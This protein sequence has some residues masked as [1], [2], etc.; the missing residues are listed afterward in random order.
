VPAQ[1]VKERQGIVPDA[2]PPAG[3]EAQYDELT[4]PT[5]TRRPLLGMLLTEYERPVAE[6]GT[7]TLTD[8]RGFCPTFRPIPEP[9]APEPTEAVTPA[10][11]KAAASTQAV[12]PLV[13]ETPHA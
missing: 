9:H 5:T 6:V 4:E 3:I 12:L 13:S 10:P 7:A 1:S 2:L 11:H 8:E